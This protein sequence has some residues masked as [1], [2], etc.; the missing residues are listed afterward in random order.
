ME[1]ATINQHSRS[2]HEAFPDVYMEGMIIKD[3]SVVASSEASTLN[4][5]G[6]NDSAVAPSSKI[7]ERDIYVE[8]TITKQ[9]LN[10]TFLEAVVGYD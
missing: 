5:G 7:F 9:S 4:I 8:G 1:G 2:F 10:G 3:A 6:K